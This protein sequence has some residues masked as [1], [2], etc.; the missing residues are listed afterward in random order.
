MSFQ[1]F[2]DRD[3]RDEV[4]RDSARLRES[5]AG[6]N[7]NPARSAYRAHLRVCTQHILGGGAGMPC[8]PARRA[9]TQ[10]A[11]G[12]RHRLSSAERRLISQCGSMQL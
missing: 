3:D 9:A 5:W 1:P 8:L 11:Q 7:I 6:A 12:T 2:F 4:I 10:E